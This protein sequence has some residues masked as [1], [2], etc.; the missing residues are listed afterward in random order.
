M[1][2]FAIDYTPVWTILISRGIVFGSYLMCSLSVPF[3]LR[4]ALVIEYPPT[5]E[6]KV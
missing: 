2:R 4:L 3:Q 6:H 5:R 1:Y